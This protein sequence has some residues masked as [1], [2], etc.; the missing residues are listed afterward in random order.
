MI[1]NGQ[2]HVINRIAGLGR[3]DDLVE[4][5]AIDGN[6]GGPGT[7]VSRSGPGAGLGIGL[8]VGTP[9]GFGVGLDGGEQIEGL[10]D[11]DCASDIE[12]NP[13]MIIFQTIFSSYF[14]AL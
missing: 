1:G 10:A 12:K 2:L 13:K 5:D 11:S 4:D 9:A 3:I 14:F 7:I 8:R 6:L